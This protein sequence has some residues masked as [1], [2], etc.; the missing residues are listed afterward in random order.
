MTAPGRAV[1]EVEDLC[2]VIP[3]KQGEVRAVRGV[4]LRLQPGEMLGI[5]GESGSGKS[6]TA[7]SIL[8]MVPRPGRV[9]SGSVRLAGRELTTLTDQEWSQVRGAGI[10]IVFQN[11]LSSLNPIMRVGKQVAEA[12][13]IHPAL[14]VPDVG[15][16]VKDALAA[17]G[18]PDP[19]AQVDKYPHQMSG[20]MRQRVMIA[21]ALA[22]S[23][24]V[25]IADEPT[26][27]LDVTTESMILDT[28]AAI[29]RDR[30]MA[31]VLISHDIGLVTSRADRVGVMY[32]GQIVESGG[33]AEV[34]A[35]PAHPYTRALLNS[36]ITP[37]TAPKSR[38]PSIAGSPPDLSQAISGC[39]FADRCSR[40]TSTCH[41]SAPPETGFGAGRTV[42]CFFPLEGAP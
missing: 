20:G 5:V 36:V 30:D 28:L 26:T 29:Q 7:L 18:L 11:P 32:G 15:R 35:R 14:E 6:L 3:S 41:E 25:L 39:A 31:I 10:S 27:A 40:A 24:R 19:A 42:R 21:I 17:A 23:P 1:L 22:A 33:S 4:S 2:T 12:F 34:A 38:L 9:A 8:G 13:A 37:D 16:A